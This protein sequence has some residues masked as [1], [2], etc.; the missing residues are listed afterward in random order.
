MEGLPNNLFR[1]DYLGSV[2]AVITT[3]DKA[4]YEDIIED[5]NALGS[6]HRGFEEGQ[7]HP[8]F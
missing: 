7:P 2:G 4:F 6:I 8:Q 1:W 3:D 5:Q